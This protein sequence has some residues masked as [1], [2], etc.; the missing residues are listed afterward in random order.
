[1]SLFG[2]L[3]QKDFGSVAFHWPFKNEYPARTEEIQEWPK[4]G[5]SLATDFVQCQ[6]MSFNGVLKIVPFSNYKRFFNRK[7]LG[8]ILGVEY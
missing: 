6:V 5:H 7:D 8:F 4:V 2:S 3:L 1:M